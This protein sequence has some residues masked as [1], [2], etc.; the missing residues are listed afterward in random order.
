MLAR[1][2]HFSASSARSNGDNRPPTPGVGIPINAYNYQYEAGANGGLG[3][4]VLNILYGD[5]LRDIRSQKG[6]APQGLSHFS[7]TQKTIES[8]WKSSGMRCTGRYLS[9]TAAA[10]L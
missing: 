6:F 8:S 1:W 2:V 7:T 9:W 10:T 5:G 3:E 4:M